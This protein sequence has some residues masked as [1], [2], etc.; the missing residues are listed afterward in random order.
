MNGETAPAA[1]LQFLSCKCPRVC[2]LPDCVCMA[3]GMVST[4][5]CRLYTCTCGNMKDEDY[6]ILE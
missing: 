3:N 1:V 4:G 6:L 5:T 2:K